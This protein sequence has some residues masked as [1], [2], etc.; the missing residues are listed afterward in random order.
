MGL[1]AEWG[2]HSMDRVDTGK[3]PCQTPKNDIEI[4]SWFWIVFWKQARAPANIVSEG[5][6]CNSTGAGKEFEWV[7]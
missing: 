4:M 3:W 6:M 1:L 7:P 5:T 2:G